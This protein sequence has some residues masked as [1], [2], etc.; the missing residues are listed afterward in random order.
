[1]SEHNP[2][3]SPALRVV[4]SPTGEKFEVSPAN[5]F[6]LTRN[7]KWTE[8]KPHPDTVREYCETNGVALPDDLTE[9]VAAE[10]QAH[11]ADI[12][13]AAA[14]VTD[15]PALAAAE[16]ADA[17]GEQTTSGEAPEEVVEKEEAEESEQ[18]DETAPELKTEPNHFADMDRDAVKA[19]IT[20]T[21]P[22]TE[23]DGR[24]GRDALVAQAL[25]LAA[26][27]AA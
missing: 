3:N 1:M 7:A 13:A 18:S 4:Y 8:T 21:F 12:P 6:D 14:P 15:T 17:A 23:I 25:E 11:A 2:N 16:T 10:V 5:F 26:A 22:G 19:Y 27:R 20:E 9:N 24:K